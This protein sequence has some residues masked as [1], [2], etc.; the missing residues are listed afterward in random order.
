MSTL[1]AVVLAALISA[2]VGP[3]VLAFI[4]ARE[5]KKEREANW[6]RED[7][8]A[9]LLLA[10]NQKIDASRDGVL[11]QL[12][13]IHALVNS[14]VTIEMKERFALTET[15][16]AL[17]REIAVLKP[18]GETQ[19]LIAAA[20]DKVAELRLGLAERHQQALEAEQ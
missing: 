2:V 16:L 15:Y 8:V 14:N 6:E 20:E 17:L 7:K 11:G 12:K 5:R 3:C 4:T 9:A 1:F 13:V 18:N 19:A 10:Q